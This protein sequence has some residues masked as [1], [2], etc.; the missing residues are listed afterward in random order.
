MVRA[1]SG[2]NLSAI[3]SR[4]SAH[5]RAMAPLVAAG[6]SKQHFASPA[7]TI[8]AEALY[9]VP[10]LL[11]GLASLVLTKGELNILSRYRRKTLRRLQKL[12]KRTATP[13]L[14]FL[15]GSLPAPA[16][17]DL[18]ILSLFGM[19]T[20]LGEG[21]ILVQHAKY[22][23]SHKMPH[24]WFCVVET[25]LEKYS[26]PCI[27]DLI[28]N[29]P[30]KLKLKSIIKKSVM[31]F[32][33]AELCR[34]AKEKK[35]LKFLRCNFIPLGKSSH[36]LWSSCPSGSS[37]AVRAAVIQAQLLCHSYHSDSMA[38]KW[39]GASEGC[40]LTGC[41]APKSDVLHLLSGDCRP[42]RPRLVSAIVR[43]LQILE[44]HP[45][46][47]SQTLTALAGSSEDWL[48]YL[49]DPSTHPAMIAFKQVNGLKSI[50]PAF[51]FSRSV[52]W[53]VHRERLRLKRQRHYLN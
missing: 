33:H 32:W 28:L 52:I 13:A 24:S 46:I 4:I 12:P 6:A 31:S 39:C 53:S 48:F 30:E 50:Y 36:P 40:S 17:L 42:L 35:S 47:H 19:V 37:S 5:I 43:G 26:L 14:F 3:Q 9:G 45:Y 7:A 11:S 1:A 41:N 34:Q 15:S 20:R 8:R 2:S 27:N 22:V 49:L 25:L 38:G 23:V 21:H 16:L 10:V 18:R 51:R 44:P 29:P